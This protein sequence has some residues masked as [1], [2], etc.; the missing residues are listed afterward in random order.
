MACINPHNLNYFKNLM[1][2]RPIKLGGVRIA[3]N[4]GLSTRVEGERTLVSLT[5]AT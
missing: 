1:K 5:D 3:T 4:E 2:K